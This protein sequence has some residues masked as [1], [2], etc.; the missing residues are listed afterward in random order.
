MIDFDLNTTSGTIEN[1][2][3]GNGEY[4]HDQ[5]CEWTFY[6]YPPGY[7]VVF[8]NFTINLE[9]SPNCVNDYLLIGQTSIYC[10]FAVITGQLQFEAEKATVTFKSNS[11]IARS[12]FHFTFR[13]LS[14]TDRQCEINNGGCSSQCQVVNQK[15]QLGCL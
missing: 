3:F 15:V 8:D 12:G 13:I 1:N 14:P 4:D 2:N 10:G 6:N 11:A 5:F 7:A 9:Q